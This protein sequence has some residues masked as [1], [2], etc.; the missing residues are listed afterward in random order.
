MGRVPE[1]LWLTMSSTP[2][3]DWSNFECSFTTYTPQLRIWARERPS[4]RSRFAA[5]QDH[6]E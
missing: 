4:S 3:Y 2:P 5:S 6:T 1:K